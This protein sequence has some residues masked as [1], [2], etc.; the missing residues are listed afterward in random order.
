MGDT[1]IPK[2]GPGVPYTQILNL[3]L[4]VKAQSR[5]VIQLVMGY[6]DTSTIQIEYQGTT[7]NFE[8]DNNGSVDPGN[9]AVPVSGSG[10]ADAESLGNAITGLWPDISFTTDSGPDGSTLL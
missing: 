3:T 10:A 6:D 1:I 4:Q 7:V 2:P 8:F 5:A 9:T